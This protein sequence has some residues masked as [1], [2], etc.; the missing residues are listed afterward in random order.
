MNVA[1]INT[2]ES[3][4]RARELCVAISNE[5]RGQDVK[6]STYVVKIERCLGNLF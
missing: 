1:K 3:L 4:A 2:T 5:W 6:Q